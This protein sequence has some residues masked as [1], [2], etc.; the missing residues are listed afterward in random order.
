MR[1]RHVVGLLS[2]GCASPSRWADTRSVC[3]FTDA[4]LDAASMAAPPVYP[5]EACVDAVLDDFEV[6]R[7]ALLDWDE[8]ADPYALVRGERDGATAVNDL[9][10]AAHALLTV[11]LGRLNE[12]EGTWVSDTFRRQLAAV[13]D[14]IASPPV[15]ALLYDFVTGEVGLTAPGA[16]EDASAGLQGRTLWLFDLP[17]GIDGAAVL[18]HEARHRSGPDHLWCRGRPMCDVDATGSVGFELAVHELAAQAA[19]DE[20]LAKLERGWLDALSERILD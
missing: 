19:D 3:G 13:G 10:W 11:D 9:L 17:A 5:S 8:L 15:S 14:P 20:A 4:P 18:V 2:V 7:E 12:V 1:L 6:D 16:R